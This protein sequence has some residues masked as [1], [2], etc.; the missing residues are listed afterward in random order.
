MSIGIIAALPREMST[1]VKDWERLPCAGRVVLYTNGR[2][3]VAYAG[4]G[5]EQAT[6]AAKAAMDAM[7][8]TVLIS[9]GL[10]G[11]CD[12]QL[13]AG[14]IVRAGCVYDAQTGEVFGDVQSKQVL[15]TTEIIASVGDKARLHSRYRAHAVDLEAAA[16]ARVAQAAGLRFQAIKAISDEADFEIEELSR[17]ATSEGQFREASFAL[18]AALRP[19]MWDKVLTL[20]RNSH[21][22]L[23]ALTKALDG[24]LDWYRKQEENDGE[25]SN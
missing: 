22:A 15:V 7:P 1:L 17:F 13:R 21:K 24:E 5:M 3:V 12:P 14:T 2:A 8:L 23:R 16:V 25:R 9:A 10:A 11:A 20:G 4:M 18:H 19:A 6:T